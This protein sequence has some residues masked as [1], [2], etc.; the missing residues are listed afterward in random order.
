METDFP[1]ISLSLLEEIKLWFAIRQAKKRLKKIRKDLLFAAWNLAVL[2]RR[3]SVLMEYKNVGLWTLEVG[4]ELDYIE[5]AIEF[6][7]RSSSFLV[8]EG[9]RLSDLIQDF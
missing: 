9:N 1:V 4:Q 7:L 5:R 8:K 6:V 2:E 3:K